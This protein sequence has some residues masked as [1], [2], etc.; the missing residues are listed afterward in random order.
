ME[1]I[2]EEDKHQDKWY[3]DAKKVSMGELTEFLRHLLEDYSHDYGTICHALAAGAIATASAMN[4]APQGGITGFQ[5]GAVMWGF[6]GHW[7]YESNKTGLRIIDYDNFLYPQYRNRFQKTISPD[8]WKALQKQAAVEIEKANDAYTKY[9]KDKQQ[10]E[11]DLAAFIA[12][13]PALSQ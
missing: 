6:I 12:K 9:L 3:E 10:Y 11:A 1:Q 2:K 4:K 7:N 5:A 13:Y 8:I